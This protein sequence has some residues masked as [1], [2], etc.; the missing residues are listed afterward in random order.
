MRLFYARLSTTR[1]RNGH[2]TTTVTITS[3]RS[4]EN[5]Y[6]TGPTGNFGNGHQNKVRYCEI[7][8]GDACGEPASPMSRR[9]GHVVGPTGYIVGMLV[10]GISIEARYSAMS[11]CN[12]L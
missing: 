5:D 9:T 11:V 3:H 6:F 4:R 7:N 8:I 1:I 2:Q 10:T 12:E